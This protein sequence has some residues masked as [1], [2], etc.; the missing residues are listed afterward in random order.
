ME[1]IKSLL[2]KVEPGNV[3]DELERELESLRVAINSLGEFYWRELDDDSGKNIPV[4][5]LT[6]NKKLNY[7]HWDS[8]LIIE[9]F[10]KEKL[11]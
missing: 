1:T 5:W 8:C 2:S 3:R 7:I 4:A 10:I 9:N 6:I 11:K